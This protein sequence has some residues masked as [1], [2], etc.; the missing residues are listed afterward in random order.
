MIKFIKC[1]DV[2]QIYE[3]VYYVICIVNLDIKDM[4][5]RNN[6]MHRKTR[7]KRQGFEV[8]T[9]AIRILR[10]LKEE[11]SFYFYDS[12]GKPTGENA[13]SL[14]DFHEKIKSAKLE[15]LVFHLQRKDFKNWVNK[16]L[17]DSKLARRIGRIHPSCDDNLRGKMCSTIEKRIKEL[18]EAS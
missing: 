1:I 15:S 17:G 8:N 10:T 9:E 13:G 4:I 16:T 3:K 5:S 18:R 14:F 12:I 2:E 6:H 11:E 7:H